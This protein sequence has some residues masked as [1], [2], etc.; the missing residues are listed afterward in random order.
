MYVLIADICHRWDYDDLKENWITQILV[1]FLCSRNWT[2]SKG[3]SYLLLVFFCHNS[4][5]IVSLCNKSHVFSVSVQLPLRRPLLMKQLIVG[6]DFLWDNK[7]SIMT[8]RIVHYLDT[9]F[10]RSPVTI[11]THHPKVWSTSCPRF[12]FFADKVPLA[13]RIPLTLG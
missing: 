13:L 1:G 8:D 6:F 5:N 4:S 2:I 7:C 12:H 9:L 11:R 10:Q 3:I